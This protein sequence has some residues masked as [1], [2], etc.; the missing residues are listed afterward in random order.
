LNLI[1]QVVQTVVDHLQ[2]RFG[3][4]RSLLDKRSTFPT[5]AQLTRECT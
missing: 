5:N 3:I 1:F 2:S 4:H